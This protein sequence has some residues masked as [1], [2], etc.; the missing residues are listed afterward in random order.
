MKTALMKPLKCS[1]T[2][3][4]K[5]VGRFGELLDQDYYNCLFSF[6]YANKLLHIVLQKM[7]HKVLFVSLKK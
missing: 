5:R 7:S 6:T 2:K 1:Y 3:L 4:H